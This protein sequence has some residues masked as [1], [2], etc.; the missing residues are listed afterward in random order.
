MLPECMKIC[1]QTLYDTTNDFAFD[2]QKEKG[3][4]SA[5]PHLQKAVLIHSSLCSSIF[6]FLVE[7]ET[8]LS[9]S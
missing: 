6:F 2:I 5:L 3:W 4:N 1:F 8:A 9:D 7:P